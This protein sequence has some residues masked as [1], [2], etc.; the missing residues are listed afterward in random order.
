MYFPQP[1]LGWLWHGL[2]P[3]KSQGRW[4]SARLVGLVLGTD[5]FGTSWSAVDVAM[6]RKMKKRSISALP[7]GRWQA[8][9]IGLALQSDVALGFVLSEQTPP[10][11]W[12]FLFPGEVRER[13]WSP[14]LSVFC[15]LLLCRRLFLALWQFVLQV[16]KQNVYLKINYSKILINSFFRRESHVFLLH[17]SSLPWKW[18][19]GTFLIT[20]IFSVIF[21][22]PAHWKSWSFLNRDWGV[23]QTAWLLGQKPETSQAC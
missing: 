23:F 2:P 22:T 3:S 18:A 9:T 15:A 21:F 11:L 20:S 6:G 19:A 4:F 8:A 12:L 10:L 16:V 7:S 17:T 13:L 14:S 5:P 1:D